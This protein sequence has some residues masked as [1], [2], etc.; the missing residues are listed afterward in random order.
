ME[1][2]HWLNEV[3][4]L[5]WLKPNPR[6]Q[7][8]KIFETFCLTNLTFQKSIHKS[9][10]VYY[11]YIKVLQFILQFKTSVIVQNFHIKC[12]LGP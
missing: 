12:T 4:S 10:T 2:L 11:L 3:D 5:F 7:N 8:N 9:F 6:Q 1:G